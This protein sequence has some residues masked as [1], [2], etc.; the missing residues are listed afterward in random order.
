[1]SQENAA[2]NR[3]LVLEKYAPLA[4][5]PSFDVQTV[6][7]RIYTKQSK[8]TDAEACR[9]R[10]AAMAEILQKRSGTGATPA[11]PVH[12]LTINEISEWAHSQSAHVS[13]VQGYAYQGTELQALTYYGPATA[14]K[15]YT[16]YF[17]LNSRV[18][19]VAKKID[20]FDPVQVGS[21]D[22]RYQAAFNRAHDSRIKFLNDLSYNY[23]ELIQL[24]Q[25]STR[26]ALRLQQQGDFSGALAKIREIEKI[27]P[28]QEIPIFDLI[29]AYSFL[30]GKAGD[31]NAQ[32]E[33]RLYLFGISQDIAHSGNGATPESAIHV[34]AISEEYDWLRVK[35][36]RMTRQ[37]LIK[38]GNDR[39]DAIEAND[40]N[41]HS[42]TVYFAVTQLVTRYRPTQVQ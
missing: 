11:D 35:N 8:E 19:S 13:G 29:S 39:Y 10:A 31:A 23:M 27:R 14:G 12:V 32:S 15:S 4:Q 21:G 22:G 17:L 30:L 6:C 37:S 28:I 25:V 36:L 42:Q 34:I 9:E 1:M 3:L 38:N 24:C 33:M 7:A 18:F 20:V 2:I 5:L 26:E 41:G 16:A 40:A